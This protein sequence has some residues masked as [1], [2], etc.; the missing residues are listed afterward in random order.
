MKILLLFN[1]EVSSSTL[2]EN[3]ATHDKKKKKKKKK[4]NPKTLN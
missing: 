2:I 3:L 4:K 1:S